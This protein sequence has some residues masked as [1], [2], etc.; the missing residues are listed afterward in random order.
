VARRRCEIV[1]RTGFVVEHLGGV[2]EHQHRRVAVAPVQADRRRSGV[3]EKYSGSGQWK[4]RVIVR[5][6]RT[7]LVTLLDVVRVETPAHSALS[8]SSAVSTTVGAAGGGRAPT[9]DTILS[10]RFIMSVAFA[11]PQLFWP[12]SPPCPS[13]PVTSLSLSENI[14]R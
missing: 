4:R 5:L 12:L 6:L 1:E 14:L 10:F 3:T 9:A 8:S 7:V 11:V 2:A 13:G